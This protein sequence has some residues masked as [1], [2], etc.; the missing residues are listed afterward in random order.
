M[1]IKSLYILIGMLLLSVAM[2]CIN[3]PMEVE[4]PVYDL[5][6]IQDSGVLRM[7]TLYSST[8]YFQYRGQEMGFQYELADQFAA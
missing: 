7:L 6:Q 1:N 2:G 4:K 5:E 3:R 8:S